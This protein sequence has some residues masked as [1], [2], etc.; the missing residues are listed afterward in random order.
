MKRLISCTLMVL[1]LALPAAASAG[2]STLVPLRLLAEAAGAVVEWDGETRMVTVNTADGLTAAIRIGDAEAT[3]GGQTVPLEGPVTLVNDRTMVSQAFMDE[4]LGMPV[5]Y[6]PESGEAKAD[7]QMMAARAFLQTLVAGDTAALYDQFSPAFKAAISPQMLAATQPG[8]AALGKLERPVVLSASSTGTHR[9]IDLLAPFANVP[10]RVIVRYDAAGLIDD[11]HM[12]AYAPLQTAG[13]PTYADPDRFTEE[14]VV[15]GEAPWTLPGTLTLPAGEG[16][17][18]VVVLVHG[19]GPNDRDETISA[20]KPFRDLAQG[21]ASQGIAALRYD[22]R[23]LVHSQKFSAIPNFT[24]QQETVEDALAAVRLLSKDERI[25]PEQIYVLGHSLG[26]LALPR[27]LAQDEEQL[28]HGGIAMAAPNSMLDTLWKQN[29]ILVR[30]GQVPPQQLPFIKGQ[31]DML[32]DPAFDPAQPPGGYLLGTPYY[33][34]DL[35]PTSSELLKDQ[36]QPV[37]FLQGGRDFQVPVS[38]FESLQAD[39]Q[40]RTNLTYNMYSQLNHV[41]TGGEGEISTLAEYGVPANVPLYVVEDIINW[42][43]TNP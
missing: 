14:E 12:N 4:L 9:N 26:G 38:E 17:F 11:F 2:E 32:R 13:A 34:K 30:T 41:F 22:K 7:A 37:L 23:T 24:V 3:V 15:V 42:I 27:I 36:T 5:A 29:E 35:I 25:N 39:L 1:L 19:S 33:W 28:I 21:L 20:V 18:P 10:M 6:D 43:R 40:A 8:F 16:P 31:L